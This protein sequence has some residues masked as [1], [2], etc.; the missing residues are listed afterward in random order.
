V[1]CICSNCWAGVRN[2]GRLPRLDM[3][4]VRFCCISNPPAEGSLGDVRICRKQTLF[5]L[6]KRHW[7]V[8]STKHLSMRRT[9]QKT[10]QNGM[11][12]GCANRSQTDSLPPAERPLADVRV[13]RKQ[14]LSPCRRTTGGCANMSQID[15]LP[16][17]E[18]PL[19]DAG[20]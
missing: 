3:T 17:A 18:G 9:E 15:S 20:K 10:H 6:Q 19:A 13:G 5:P 16:P 14:T 4:S 11:Q 1:C 12:L 7:R 8:Q 2:P